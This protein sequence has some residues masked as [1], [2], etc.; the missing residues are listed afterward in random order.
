MTRLKMNRK[1]HNGI[2]Q[3]V[4]CKNENMFVAVFFFL[5]VRLLRHL[6]APQ[7][8]LTARQRSNKNV[9]DRSKSKSNRKNKIHT[10]FKWI[11]L[12]VME[13]LPC[14]L[15]NHMPPSTHNNTTNEGVECVSSF[16]ISLCSLHIA[17]KCI[18]I[19]LETSWLKW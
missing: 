5:I 4:T 2:K 14:A 6:G 18:N 7:K 12:H 3:N 17:H 1:V 13:F 19:L 9:N 16:S 10:Q 11:I 8:Q 15:H